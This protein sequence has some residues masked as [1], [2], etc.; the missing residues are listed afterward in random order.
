MIPIFCINLER[1][2]ERKE[3]IQKEWIDKLN[4]N[5]TFWNGYDRRNIEN[6][7][8]IYSYD[9]E[10]AINTI[11]RQLSYGELACATSFC[12]LYEYLL[13]NN[14]EKVIIMEDDIT[15]NF[16]NKSVLFDT[17]EKIK[18]EFNQAE[19]ILLHNISPSQKKTQ[20][21]IF[22]QKKIEGSLCHQA[23]WGNQLFYIES[24]SIKK[25]YDILKEMTMPADLTQNILA[26][27]NLVCIANS[28]L[29]FHEW[30]GPNSITY[31]GN[32]FRNTKRRFI[33]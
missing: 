17:I 12:M 8:F 7:K 15:P 30:M 31:I 11:G 14:Y 6:N 21:K 5:I 16:T 28:P 27:Q 13:E 18:D 25:T 33:Q 23:P 9:K 19:I 20:E 32:D 22:Y 29:C 2:T 1:A 3:L 26:K 10:L 4:L 24:N